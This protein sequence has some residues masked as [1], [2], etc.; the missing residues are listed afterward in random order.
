LPKK[1]P[2][3]KPLGVAIRESLRYVRRTLGLVWKSSPPLTTA[4]VVVIL[5]GSVLGPAI[6]LAGKHIVDAVV[7]GSRDEA[8]RWVAVE[9]GL[10]LAQASVNR[11]GGLVRGVLGSRLG[12]DINIAITTSST[13][14]RTTSTRRR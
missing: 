11:G 14:S 7:A 12:H 6:A 4:Y 8:V 9:L 10:V 13:S 1:E 2:E 3:K 5:L